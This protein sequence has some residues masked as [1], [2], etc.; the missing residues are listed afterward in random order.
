VNTIGFPRVDGYL[1]N[2]KQDV[3]NDN[4]YTFGF[5][6]ALS[7]ESSYNVKFE[8]IYANGFR[9]D[10]SF[11]WTVRTGS[12]AANGLS[13]RTSGSMK[14]LNLPQGFGSLNPNVLEQMDSCTQYVGCIGKLVARTA[15]DYRQRTL[16][17]MTKCRS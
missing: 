8:W 15:S 14:A 10:S 6:P 2:F 4:L 17:G 9:D 5:R 12:L 7:K 1:N 3:T 16:R 11:S 13:L